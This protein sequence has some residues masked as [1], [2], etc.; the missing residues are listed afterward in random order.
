MTSLVNYRKTGRITIAGY[1]WWKFGQSV[2]S[3]N[4]LGSTAWG[5]AAVEATVGIFF[6]DPVA[7]ALGGAIIRGGQLT[8]RSWIRTMMWAMKNPAPAFTILYIALMP[9]AIKERQEL[10]EERGEVEPFGIYSWEAEAIPETERLRIPS[11]I[12][13]RVF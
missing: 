3:G 2:R 12:G 10:K 7:T 8:K 1:A 5:V 9:F 11:I 13:G 4:L 6:P